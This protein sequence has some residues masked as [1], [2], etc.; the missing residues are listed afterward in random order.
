MA[1]SSMSNLSIYAD[2]RK[3]KLDYP[4]YPSHSALN[5]ISNDVFQTRTAEPLLGTVTIGVD[6]AE[7]QHE[8]TFEYAPSN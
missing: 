3:G 2:L 7:E 5:G 4:I 8:E 1:Y 6:A